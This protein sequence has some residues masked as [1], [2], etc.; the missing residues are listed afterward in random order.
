MWVLMHVVVVAVRTSVWCKVHVQTARTRGGSSD[1]GRDNIDDEE[2]EEEA[3]HVWV[4]NA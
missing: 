1:D 2:A 4:D 3:L